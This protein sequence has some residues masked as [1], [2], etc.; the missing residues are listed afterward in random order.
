MNKRIRCFI[1]GTLI[2]GNLTLTGCSIPFEKFLGADIQSTQEKI[3][4]GLPIDDNFKN[5]DLDTYNKIVET[6]FDTIGNQEFYLKNFNNSTSFYDPINKYF[7]TNYLNKI[8]DGFEKDNIKKV[9]ENIYYIDNTK[10]YSAKIIGAGKTRFGVKLEVEIASVDD[11]TSFG[12][13]TIELYF[14]SDKQIYKAEIINELNTALNTTKPLDTDSLICDNSAFITAFNDFILPFKNKSIYDLSLDSEN[15][16]DFE[17]EINTLIDNL[18]LTNQDKDVLVTLFKAGKATF[19]NYGISQYIHYDKN[20]EPIS[21]Y[22][23]EF[24]LNDDYISFDFYY[25]RLEKSIYKVTM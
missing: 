10:F 12:L 13:Q 5:E 22:T 16:Q 24:S 15:K 20:A 3:I 17:Y 18:E 6:I 14:N 4:V 19:D 2:I 8:I 9:I 25:N 21:V 1:L 11:T 7:D 23:V